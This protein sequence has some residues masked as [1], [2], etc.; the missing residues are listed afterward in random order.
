[1]RSLGHRRF[2]FLLLGSISQCTAGHSQV[3]STKLAS[4]PPDQKSYSTYQSLTAQFFISGTTNGDK[5]D[6]QGKLASKP[7]FLSILLKD[8]VFDSPL[9]SLTVR[10]DKVYHKNHAYNKITRMPLAEFR[11]V[12]IM[13][14]AVPFKFFM[15][16]LQGYPPKVYQEGLM[17]EERPG[18][19]KYMNIEEGF[20]IGV[21]TQEGM[22]TEMEYFL[23]GSKSGLRVS[24]RGNCN[25][26]GRYFPKYI[27]LNNTENNDRLQLK[28]SRCRSKI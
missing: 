19:Y 21:S 2:L 4:P 15:P 3:V 11:W 1:M 26:K 14:T 7:D 10:N 28:F 9:I 22:I 16:V 5:Q 12:E 18:Y 25:P 24:L 27:I 6:Y 8:T 13:G 23:L 20:I 17:T